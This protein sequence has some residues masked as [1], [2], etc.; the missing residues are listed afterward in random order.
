MNLILS[1]WFTFMLYGAGRTVRFAW[2]G[3][4]RAAQRSN[5]GVIPLS[6][7]AVWRYGGGNTQSLLF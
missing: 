5:R 3:A 4:R 2:K 7:A 1:E 6:A